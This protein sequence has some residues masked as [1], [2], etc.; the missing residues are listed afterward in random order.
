M[1]YMDWEAA[2]LGTGSALSVAPSG[3]TRSGNGPAYLP[4]DVWSEQDE[5]R[6]F[7]EEQFR[8][9]NDGRTEA[10]E[11]GVRLSAEAWAA[12]LKAQSDARRAAEAQRKAQYYDNVEAGTNAAMGG[13]DGEEIRR[14]AE[15]QAEARSEQQE[16]GARSGFQPE[17]FSRSERLDRDE[18]GEMSQ[19]DRALQAKALERQRRNDKYA[20]MRDAQLAQMDQAVAGGASFYLPPGYNPRELAFVN[21]EWAKRTGERKGFQLPEYNAN[22]QSLSNPNASARTKVDRMSP[23]ELTRFRVQSQAMGL[24]NPNAP[25][26]VGPSAG[27]YDAM[28]AAMAQVNVSPYTSVEQY[29]ADSINPVS[30]QA[31]DFT[32][33]GPGGGGGSGPQN[34]TER[35]FNKTSVDQGKGILRSLM[36]EMLGRAPTDDEVRRYVSALN[37]KEAATPQVVSVTY[38]GGGAT[39]TTKTVSNAPEP[40]EVLRDQVEA[41]SPE[42]MQR[43]EAGGYMNILN[44]MLGM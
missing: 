2:L 17:P 23:E 35:I 22:D 29:L 16:F 26:T 4:M 5:T 20:R 30:G 39:V 42:E 3:V 38:G 18:Y 43:Y 12:Q 40:D 32:N 33:Y 15:G 25:L 44:Q 1:P 36:A 13:A 41:A 7:N 11:E 9:F 31:G 21:N 10:N 19:Q 37:K 14:R 6:A 24:R 8:V 27:D 28:A 34:R